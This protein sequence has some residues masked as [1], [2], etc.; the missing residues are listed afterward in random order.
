MLSVAL[1]SHDDFVNNTQSAF[2]D[3]VDDV[4]KHLTHL[5]RYVLLPGILYRFNH[6]RCRRAAFV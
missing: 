6:I 1:I 4:V 2:I 3:G 5:H